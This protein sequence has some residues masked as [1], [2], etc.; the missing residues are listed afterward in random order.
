MIVIGFVDFTSQTGETMSKES[1]VRGFCK[2][3]ETVGI[4]PVELAKFAAETKE[5][6]NE[7][8][9]KYKTD[10]Y[11]P[12]LVSRLGRKSPIVYAPGFGPGLLDNAYTYGDSDFSQAEEARFSPTRDPDHPGNLPPE[13]FE[14]KGVDRYMNWLKAHQL[15]RQEVADAAKPYEGNKSV[16]RD[17]RMPDLGKVYHD[18]ML[19]STGGVSRVSAPAKK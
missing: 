10:G 3:A 12:R 18:S 9:P 4:D 16:Y 11:A 8:Q 13:V 15:A 7:E 19:K 6:A 2:A 5:E 17:K 14:G 1:Y